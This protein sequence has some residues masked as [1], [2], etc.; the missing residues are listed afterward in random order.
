[1]VVK[2]PGEEGSAQRLA[3]ELAQGRVWLGFCGG[4][5]EGARSK[6]IDTKMLAH[7]DE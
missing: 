6:A 7:I 3:V 1:M 4:L 5:R 2:A